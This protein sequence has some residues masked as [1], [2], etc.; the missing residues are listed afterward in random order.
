MIQLPLVTIITPAYNRANLVAETIESV[1]NQDYPRLEYIVLDDGSTDG[2]LEVIK[3]YDGRLR[4]ESHPNMGETRTVNRGFK[5]ACGEIIG[6]VNSDDPL[7]PRAVT[8]LVAALVNQPQ[9]VVAYPDWQI[10]NEDG[11][12]RQIVRSYD[13][14]GH[15]DMVRRHYCLPGPGAFFRRSVVEKIGDRDPVFRYVADLDFWFRVGLLGPLFH[16]PEVLATFRTHSGSATVGQQGTEMAEEHLELVKKFFARDDLPPEL[17]V[18]KQE[19]IG[20]ACF[21][22]AT[23]CGKKALRKKLSFFYRA[24]RSSPVKYFGEYAVRWPILIF[25]LLGISHLKIYYNMK[26]IEDSFFRRKPAQRKAAHD[27]NC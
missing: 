9:V 4:W 2:T 21:V 10:I 12:V 25:S 13:Y 7:L 17:C 20:S 23:V 18:I 8:K 14:T 24:L 5:L 19:A 16:V 6:V 15:A 26:W 1:L 27:E 22:A 3:R 11:Q